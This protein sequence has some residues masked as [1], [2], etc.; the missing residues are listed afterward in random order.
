ML[1]HQIL[2][3]LASIVTVLAEVNITKPAQGDSF[4]GSGGTANVEIQWDIDNLYLA[5]K[6]TNFTVLLCTGQ[7]EAIDCQEKPLISGSSLKADLKTVKLSSDKVA[8]GEYFFQFYIQYPGGVA[9]I[10]YSYRF[11]LTGM[12]GANSFT[13]PISATGPPPSFAFSYPVDSSLHSVPYTKQTGVVRYAPMQSQPGS[14]VT[15]S[16]WSRRFP[17]SSVS[18]YSTYRSRPNVLTT[19]TIPWT[20]S[21]TS[22]ANWASTAAYPTEFYPASSRVTKAS[23]STAAKKKRWLDI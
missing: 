17:T 18:Y 13:A 19:T 7:D 9:L 11:K 14:K 4:S 3:I 20:Y 6:V 5:E 2:I 22:A 23:L 1:L 8:N 16:T 15:H 21:R 12:T 10:A